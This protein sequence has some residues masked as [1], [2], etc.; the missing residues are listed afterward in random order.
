M[1]RTLVFLL[2]VLMMGG[3]QQLKATPA[4]TNSANSG[5]KIKIKICLEIEFG[6]PNKDCRGF[7]ICHFG[8]SFI[9]APVPSGPP[10]T[11]AV[12]EAYFDDENHF[13]TEF[14]KSN[15]KSETITIYLN[16]KFIV[17]EDFQVPRAVLDALQYKGNVTI[18]AGQY[19]VKDTG[20]TLVVKF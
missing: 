3:M 14:K 12:S 15:T 13:V 6:N 10:F 20:Q 7:G 8:I 4:Q 9:D 17:E 1:K 5:P 11:T 18:K 19:D 2:V 16:Q